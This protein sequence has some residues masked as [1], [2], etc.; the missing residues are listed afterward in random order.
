MTS[1]EFATLLGRLEPLITRKDT[2]MRRVT[3]IT[4]ASACL[5]NFLCDRRLEAYMTPALVDWEDVDHRDNEG[6]W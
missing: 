5:N 4:L 6:A 1:D 3:K 2:K